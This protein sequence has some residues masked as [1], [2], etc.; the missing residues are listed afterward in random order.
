MDAAAVQ[1][2]EGGHPHGYSRTHNGHRPIQDKCAR[3]QRRSARRLKRAASAL[4][5]RAGF[6]L[7]GSYALW[8]FGGPE[9][10]HDVDFVVAEPDTEK[11]ATTFDRRASPSNGHPRTG[12]SRPASATTWCRHPAPD[13][14]SPVGLRRRRA[15]NRRD[16]DPDA[17]AL[18]DRAHPEIDGPSTNTT[19][20][21]RSLIPGVRAVRERVDWA[22]C[23][24]DR[25]QRFR[26]GVPDLGRPAGNHRV[27][28][29]RRSRAATAPTARATSGGSRTSKS[30]PDS[31]EEKHHPFRVVSARGDD[32]RVGTVGFDSH[33][34]R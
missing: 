26:F 22:G 20:I 13:R 7:A 10:V 19:A 11:A 15:R 3:T 23:S 30:Q 2:V 14:R 33:R 16:R 32:A 25:R 18:G 8:V 31:G 12:C 5:A 9:P 29:A 6:A 21:S 1:D 24:R 17:G 28:A 4:K 27:T 34:C